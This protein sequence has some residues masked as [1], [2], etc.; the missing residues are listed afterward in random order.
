MSRPFWRLLVNEQLVF[1]GPAARAWA[2]Y[3]LRRNDRGLVELRNG[4]G[5]VKACVIS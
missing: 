4:A 1:E 2:Q 3:Q 5:V